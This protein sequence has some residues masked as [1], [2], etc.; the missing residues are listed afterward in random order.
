MLDRKQS[1]LRRFEA[2]APLD[3][4]RAIVQKLVEAQI[5]ELGAGLQPVEVD[6]RDLD[7]SGIDTHQLER[8]A[9]DV[10][11]RSRAARHA[12]DERGLA[13]AKVTFEKKQ[14]ALAQAS[15]EVLA[16]RLGFRWRAG[17]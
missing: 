11:G 16:G 10:C 8:R 13:R 4:H 5:G 7:A 6:V 17:D 2:V 15:T 14:I 12:P 9:C 1:S 3:H